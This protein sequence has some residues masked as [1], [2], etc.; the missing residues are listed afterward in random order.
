MLAEGR[1]RRASLTAQE[2]GSA[3]GTEDTTPGTST[4]SLLLAQLLHAVLTYTAARQALLPSLQ[5]PHRGACQA[6]QTSPGPAACTYTCLATRRQCT[7]QYLSQR[8]AQPGPRSSSSS[9]HGLLGTPHSRGHPLAA[10]Y[11]QEPER[12]QLRHSHSHRSTGHHHAQSQPGR[13]QRL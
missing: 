7:C 5:T 3:R 8:R 12:G 4:A 6:P 9:Q 10:L 11:L 13:A 1:P 2:L